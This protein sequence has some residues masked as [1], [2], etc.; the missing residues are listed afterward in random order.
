MY[1]VAAFIPYMKH[2]L[3]KNSHAFLKGED[4]RLRNSTSGEGDSFQPPPLP[5]P[6]WKNT[7]KPWSDAVLYLPICDIRPSNSYR[8]W[9]ILTNGHEMTHIAEN[10]TEKVLGLFLSLLSV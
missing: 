6:S 8:I 9:Y 2:V 3:L 1:S 10:T 7:G 4:S 5:S